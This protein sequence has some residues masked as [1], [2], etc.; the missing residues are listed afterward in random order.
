MHSVTMVGPV[1]YRHIDRPQ[2]VGSLACPRCQTEQVAF[3][4]FR[5]RIVE[6]LDVEQP[7]Y[8][9]LKVPKYACRNAACV[10]KYF[11]PP[12]ADAAPCAHTSRRLQ[13]TSRQMYRGEKLAL[14]RRGSDRH[15]R[16]KAETCG[17][18]WEACMLR[19]RRW[20]TLFYRPSI[21]RKEGEPTI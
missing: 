17:R 8:L 14:S 2:F 11:T 20:D 7:T 1:V 9:V 12:V 18:R 4:S 13:Q 21:T 10:R 5:H 16:R 15:R 3:H 6:H 19:L